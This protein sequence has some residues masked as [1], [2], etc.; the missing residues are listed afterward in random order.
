MGLGGILLVGTIQFAALLTPIALGLLGLI[1][2]GLA[3]LTSILAWALCGVPVSYAV[4][5]RVH[6]QRRARLAARGA[7]PRLRSA[8][9]T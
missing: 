2:G 8:R 5:D 9:A 1:S 6:A 4:I 3:G 7:V